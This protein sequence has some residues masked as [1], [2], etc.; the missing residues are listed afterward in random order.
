M[1]L[2][3]NLAVNRV[4]NK[5]NGVED[6]N[7]ILYSVVVLPLLPDFGFV[8]VVSLFL[9]GETTL[10]TFDFVVTTVSLWLSWSL[11]ALPFLVACSSPESVFSV[12]FLFFVSDFICLSSLFRTSCLL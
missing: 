1:L 3:G 6:Y 10:S 5:Q 8:L 4:R 7:T 11:S 9:V 12:C 2:V